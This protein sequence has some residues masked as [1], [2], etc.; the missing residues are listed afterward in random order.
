MKGRGVA[1]HLEVD[2]SGLGTPGAAEAPLGGDDLVH[3]EAL[4]G[5]DGIPEG[6]VL[7][8]DASVFGV[9][10]VAEDEDAG[11]DAMGDGVAR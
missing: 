5:A 6:E 7:G 10:L 3:E 11:V 8:L 1:V 9:V 2:G 4:E